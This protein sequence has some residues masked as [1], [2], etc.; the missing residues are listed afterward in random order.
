MALLTE[1]RRQGRIAQNDSVDAAFAVCPALPS[2]LGDIETTLPRRTE[3]VGHDSNQNTKAGR[4]QI[5]PQVI[6]TWWS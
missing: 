1:N 2:I 5:M 6:E 4:N 3:M